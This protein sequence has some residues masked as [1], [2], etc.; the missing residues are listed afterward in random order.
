MATTHSLFRFKIRTYTKTHLCLFRSLFVSNCSSLS[1]CVF[2]CGCLKQFCR[3]FVRCSKRI[4]SCF[5]RGERDR[6]RDREAKKS[7]ID[8]ER[9]RES[10]IDI[11]RERMIERELW[12]NGEGWKEMDEERMKDRE[13]E[14]DRSC[15][16][17]RSTGVREGLMGVSSR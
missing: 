11:E 15:S 17:K 10:M 6:E 3:E 8:R 4:F 1:V 7:E 2:M 9:Q 12:R 14:R 16:S 13:R 5:E